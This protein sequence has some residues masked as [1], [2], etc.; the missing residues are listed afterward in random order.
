MAEVELYEITDSGLDV[1][2]AFMS[3]YATH[4]S[5]YLSLV[6]G[7]CFVAYTAGRNLTTFQVIVASLM[8]IVAAEMQA[9]MMSLWVQS[10]QDVLREL[11]K[12]NPE[13]GDRGNIAGRKLFGIALWQAGIFACLAFMWSI[14]HSKTE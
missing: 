9:L 13:M 7:Y 1:V 2:A 4:V 11:A 8:F 14:R 5:I 10:S 3:N 12:I 6:F